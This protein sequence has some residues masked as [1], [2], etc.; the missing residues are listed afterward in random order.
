MLVTGF[1]V[2]ANATMIG[3]MLVVF[4]IAVA[5]AMARGLN[6]DCGCFGNTDATPVG[7]KKIGENTVMLLMAL[8]LIRYGHVARAPSRRQSGATANASAS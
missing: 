4:I 1:W 2:R 8:W 5:S 3:I 7:W 6:I